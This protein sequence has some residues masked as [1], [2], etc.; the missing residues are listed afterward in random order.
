MVPSRACFDWHLLSS[1]CHCKPEQSSHRL[2]W[3]KSRA[4]AAGVP[5][6]GLCS[7]IHELSLRNQR[8]GRN[9][10]RAFRSRH[11]RGRR[12]RAGL[13]EHG[14]LSVSISPAGHGQL[15]VR[16]SPAGR[17]GTQRGSCPQGSESRAPAGRRRGMP[18]ARQRQR[19]ARRQQRGRR[20]GAPRRP[21]D[22][23]GARR[24]E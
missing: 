1:C 6:L 5:E 14:Q 10:T 13:P 19:Q 8:R 18:G 3:Q 23:G 16:V 22:A 4:V 11:P 15:S 17:G 2:L 7:H 20:S 12:R 24:G 21:P 9:Q